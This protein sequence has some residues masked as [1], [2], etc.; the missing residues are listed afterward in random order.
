MYEMMTGQ[1]LWHEDRECNIARADD[2]AVLHSWTDAAKAEAL[3]RVPDLW[4]RALL[5]W[6]LSKEPAAR[7]QSFEAVLKHPFFAEPLAHPPRQ[8][9]LPRAADSRSGVFFWCAAPS[10]RSGPPPF[11]RF[12]VREIRSE[13]FLSDG[14]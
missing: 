2:Y 8:T 9:A 10:R 13:T 6:L 4:G 3:S 7:P 5:W 12:C 11:V 1:R 14:S